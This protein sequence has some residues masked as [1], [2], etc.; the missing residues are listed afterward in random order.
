[1]VISAS[2][3]REISSTYRLRP[4]CSYC[5]R[6][7][8]TGPR[9]TEKEEGVGREDNREKKMRRWEKERRENKEK[10]RKEADRRK[11]REIEGHLLTI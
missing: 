11:D 8:I 6:G 10:F 2:K 1:M 9:W 5:D 4:L 3:L 7:H